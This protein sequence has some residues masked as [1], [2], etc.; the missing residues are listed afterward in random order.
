[1]E[2]VLGSAQFGLDYG[3]SNSDGIMNAHEISR[4]LSYAQ[5]IKIT[6]IDTAYA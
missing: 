4:V 2:L 5:K 1:M 3:V 6:K